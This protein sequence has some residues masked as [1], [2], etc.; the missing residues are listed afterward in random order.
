LRPARSLQAELA[1]G[2]A[3]LAVTAANLQQYI[4]ALARYKS[5]HCMADASRAL[6]R[7]LRGVL[8]GDAV[9]AL[10]RCFSHDEM[11]AMLA[12]LAELDAAEWRAHTR[13]EH[14]TQ[15][16]PQLGWLWAAV[17]R[18]APPQRAALLTFA[19]GSST[20]PAGGFAA[21][22]GFNGAPHPFTGTRR[23][24]PSPSA[25]HALPAVRPPSSDAFASC[26]GP[27]GQP[28]C[29]L[30]AETPASVP[31]GGTDGCFLNPP[32]A[33]CPPAVCLV[34]A[35][36]DSRLPRASTC[37]NTLF[38]PRYSCPAVLEARLGQALAGAHVFD[39]GG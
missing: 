30:T 28:H 14:C 2:G 24:A 1:P 18:W 7:G 21:L 9:D 17:A 26:R 3:T 11:N 20:L 25:M 39:E 8:S 10:A 22:R 29:L 36:G 12:G 5:V 33:P 32:P 31:L 27:A 6:G 35:E 34:A 13:L 19:T 16:T 4:A 37:F 23:H 15:L 38:L